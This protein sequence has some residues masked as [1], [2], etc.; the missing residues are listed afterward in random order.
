[1]IRYTVM[2][3]VTKDWFEMTTNGYY[4]IGKCITDPRDGHMCRVM[5]VEGK[6]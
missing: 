1:M 5:R 2:D 6:V 3:L 4:A